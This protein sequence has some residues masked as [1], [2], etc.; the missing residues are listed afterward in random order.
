MFVMLIKTVFLTFCHHHAEHIVSSVK[1]TSKYF[2]NLHLKV[3]RHKG[4]ECQMVTIK[5]HS[6]ETFPFGKAKK[7]K[8]DRKGDKEWI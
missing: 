1:N 7:L 5:K 6:F 8:S 2:K 3:I 4:Q